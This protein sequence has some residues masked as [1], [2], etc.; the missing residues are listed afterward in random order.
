M[1]KEGTKKK[2]MKGK[3]NISEI[4]NEFVTHANRDICIREF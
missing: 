3:V 2:M 1:G 4:P